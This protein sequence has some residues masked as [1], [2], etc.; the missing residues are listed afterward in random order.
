VEH[1]KVKHIIICGHTN[2]G[3]CSAAYSKEYL[4]GMLDMWLSEL[5][6]TIDHHK[7]KLSGITDEIV[8]INVTNYYSLG[9][10]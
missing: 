5:K 10:T 7:V 3:G 2:C 4:G 8:R 9:E 1:L 6:E